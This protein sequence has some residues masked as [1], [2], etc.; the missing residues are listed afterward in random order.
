MKLIKSTFIAGLTL[1][2]TI[3]NGSGQATAQAWPDP[4][5]TLV[6]VSNDLSTYYQ[7]GKIK[8]TV[9]II[10]INNSTYSDTVRVWVCPIANWDGWICTAGQFL[11]STTPDTTTTSMVL[12][13]P[14]LNLGFGNYLVT[15]V[16]FRNGAVLPNY[17]LMYPRTG[18][19][20]I[21]GMATDIP[22]VNLAVADFQIT[23]PP[24]PPAPEPEPPVTDPEPPA[25]EPDSE[26]EPELESE[27]ESEPE[28]ELA[29]ELEPDSEP[30]VEPQSEVDSDRIETSPPAEPTQQPVV[31]PV[32]TEIENQTA[33]EQPAEPT[34]Q[35]SSVSSPVV[36]SPA[37]NT[38]STAP[39]P[40]VKPVTSP[41]VE[42]TNTQ[43]NTTAT[44]VD[45]PTISD[46]I[47]LQ[48]VMKRTAIGRAL[49]KVAISITGPAKLKRQIPAGIGKIKLL[50]TNDSRLTI[51]LGSKVLLTTNLNQDQ[52]L[53]WRSA[54][55]T[56]LKLI[57][58]GSNPALL[59]DALQLNGRLLTSPTFLMRN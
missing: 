40:A 58:T 51:K 46:V 14:S 38:N 4:L 17:T 13:S 3:T 6:S 35:S 2:F 19:V 26:P 54:K 59:I 5:V 47:K 52:I 9:N 10:R 37:D 15:A 12:E 57:L 21:G 49:G 34:S 43:P 42:I 16:S 22:L 27:S 25:P 28:P 36:S 29:P 30:A 1:L 53:S 23:Q 11:V 18:I 7:D 45:T 56:T 44:N 24:E 41:I 32:P 55:P 48:P 39:Q 8:F 20:T 50:A 33:I 31:Q